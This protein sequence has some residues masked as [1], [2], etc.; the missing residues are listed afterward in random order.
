MKNAMIGRWFIL[1]GVMG[2]HRYVLGSMCTSYIMM[3]VPQ[4]WR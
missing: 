2:T 3:E 4:S 1:V